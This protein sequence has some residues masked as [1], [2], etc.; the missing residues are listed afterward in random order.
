MANI[1]AYILGHAAVFLIF[2]LFWPFILADLF[3][4]RVFG[5]ELL[6]ISSPDRAT[7]WRVF[8]ETIIW[9]AVICVIN[10]VIAKG[11]NF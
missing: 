8:V 9:A 1:L 4:P 10:Y 11:N 6:S 5:R 2:L 7:Y 3:F